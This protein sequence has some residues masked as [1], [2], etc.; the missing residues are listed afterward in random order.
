MQRVEGLERCESFL[1]LDIRK[2]AY[3]W[4]VGGVATAADGSPSDRR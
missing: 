3:G 4:G 2:L 1:V